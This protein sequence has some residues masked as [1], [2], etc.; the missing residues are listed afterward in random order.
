[1]F[2]ET[3]KTMIIEIAIKKLYIFF[4]IPNK[5]KL[6]TYF[7]LDGIHNHNTL[8]AR[9]RNHLTYPVYFALFHIH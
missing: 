7:K 6:H 1:M 5:R 8:L 2:F 9:L 3:T 4:K